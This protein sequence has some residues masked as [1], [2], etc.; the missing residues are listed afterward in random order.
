MSMN[1]PAKLVALVAL[2]AM[3]AVAPAGA[4]PGDVSIYSRP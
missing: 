4:D 2:W 3:W 1:Q